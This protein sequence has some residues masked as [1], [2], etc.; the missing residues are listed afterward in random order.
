MELE[1]EVLFAT[2]RLQWRVLLIKMYLNFFHED[3]GILN[4]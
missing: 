2:N 4:I 1:K 3:A